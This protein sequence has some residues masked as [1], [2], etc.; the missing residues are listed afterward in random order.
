MKGI[1]S[2][3]REVERYSDGG[4]YSVRVVND[5]KEEEIHFCLIIIEKRL[6][7]R[8]IQKNNSTRQHAIK[9]KEHC[10]NI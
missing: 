9:R 8:M 7:I 6:F 10:T 1:R 4:K 2:R 5:R 3:P